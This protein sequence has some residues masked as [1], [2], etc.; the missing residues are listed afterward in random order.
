MYIQRLYNRLKQIHNLKITR[1][2]QQRNNVGT[3]IQHEH[4]TVI[5]IPPFCQIFTLT[6]LITY[7]IKTTE[8]N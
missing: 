1:F 8:H 3:N 6:K 4:N 7:Y 2:K 5:N